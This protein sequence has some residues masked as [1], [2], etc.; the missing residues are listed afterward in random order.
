MA[1]FKIGFAKR[2]R[3]D[4]K[5]I[6]KADADR[7]LAA[8]ADLANDPRPAGAKKLKGE[9]LHR[10]RIGVYR[11]IYQ[12]FDDHLVVTVVKVAHR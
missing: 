12:I 7:I 11:V 6:A 3:R 9:E 4:F 8:I 10:I 5:K 1:S 2:V